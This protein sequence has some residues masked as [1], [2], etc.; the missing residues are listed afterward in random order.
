MSVHLWR[1]TRRRARRN[2]AGSKRTEKRP[3]HGKQKR[4]DRDA[5]MRARRYRTRIC[6]YAYA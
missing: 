4:A 6:V 2:D 5:Y 3:V 1:S